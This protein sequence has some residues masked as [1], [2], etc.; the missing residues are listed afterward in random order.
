MGGGRRKGDRQT[1]VGGWREGERQTNT[2]DVGLKQTEV[3]EGRETYTYRG[4]RC[5][6]DKG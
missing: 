4:G 5:E 6:T 1:D 3:G 2:G